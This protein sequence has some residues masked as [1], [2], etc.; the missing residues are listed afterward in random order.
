MHDTGSADAETVNAAVF[1]KPLLDTLAGIINILS[2]MIYYKNE[3]WS[4]SDFI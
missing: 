4:Y 1:K 2:K 3:M